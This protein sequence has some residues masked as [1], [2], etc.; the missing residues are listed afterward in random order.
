MKFISLDLSTRSTGLAIFNNNKLESYK[1]ITASS[2]DLIKRIQ[3][4]TK[5]IKEIIEENTEIE[6]IILEEVHIDSDNV[7]TKNI[8]THRAL[9]WIQASINFMVH[10]NFPNI[11]IEYVYPGTWRKTCGIKTGRGVKRDSLKTA[12]IQFVKDNY[13]IDV[14]DDVADAICIGYH[15]LNSQGHNWT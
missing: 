3:K 12:D 14:N 7:A 10:D 6:K 11:I 4:I 8:A 15:I 5:E 2:N 1:L 9:M 13:N